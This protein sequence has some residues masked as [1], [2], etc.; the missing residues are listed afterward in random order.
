[1]GIEDFIF[2]SSPVVL[3]IYT[4]QTPLTVDVSGV[5]RLKVIKDNHE[6][7]PPRQPR[8]QKQTKKKKSDSK[9]GPGGQE[10]ERA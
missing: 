5:G 7:H 9:G 1:M 10:N 3:L 4:P 2:V 8:E 6:K